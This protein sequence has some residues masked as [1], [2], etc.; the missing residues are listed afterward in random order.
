MCD[1]AGAVWRSR[2]DSLRLF[3]PA[4]YS[5]LPGSPFPGSPDRHP[6]KDEVADYLTGY[7]RRLDLPVRLNVRVERVQACSTGVGFEVQTSAG[8]WRVGQMMCATG[9][10]QQPVSP[11]FAGEL[12]GVVQMRLVRLLRRHA[13]RQAGARATGT[14]PEDGALSLWRAAGSSPDDLTRERAGRSAAA[15]HAT[16]PRSAA[17]PPRAGLPRR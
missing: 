10:F 2:W 6:P 12:D 16:A 8:R 9:P 15:A 1:P 5:G 3:T 17:G 11:S 14:E 7:A 13:V 4:G